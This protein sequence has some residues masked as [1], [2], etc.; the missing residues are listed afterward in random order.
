MKLV[1]STRN[2]VGGRGKKIIL[3]EGVLHILTEAGLKVSHAKYFSPHKVMHLKI[4]HAF[5]WIALVHS[6]QGVIYRYLIWQNKGVLH[7][8]H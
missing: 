6:K 2:Q 3:P 5:I 7:T 8:A 4:L 1:T